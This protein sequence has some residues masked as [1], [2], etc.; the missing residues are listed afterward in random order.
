MG[1]KD[2]AIH[3]VL[4]STLKNRLRQYMIHSWKPDC[5]LCLT[6]QEE[7]EL[8]DHLMLAAKVGYGKTQW[9]FMNLVETYMNSQPYYV[10][11][12]SKDCDWQQALSNWNSKS[13]DHQQWI[14]V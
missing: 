3:R 2:A 1:N 7:N 6:K 12:S 11:Q 4:P 14:V 10:H 8:T 5:N 9:D 13:C